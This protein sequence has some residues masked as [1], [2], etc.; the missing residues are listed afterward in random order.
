[1]VNNRRSNTDRPCPR[2]Q[3]NRQR[4][5]YSSNNHIVKANDWPCNQARWRAWILAEKTRV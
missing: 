1:V 5:N 2:R 3:G 4:W